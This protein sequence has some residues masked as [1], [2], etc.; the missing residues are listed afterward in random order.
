MKK[1]EH[2]LLPEQSN[3]L[4]EEEAI[5]SISLTRNVAKKINEIIDSI[6]ELDS[7]NYEKHQEQD[8]EIRKGILYMKDNLLNTLH[9]LLELYEKDGFIEKYVKKYTVDLEMQIMNLLSGVSEDGELIDVRYGANGKLYQTAGE[10]IRKQLA[11]LLELIQRMYA[12]NSSVYDLD[13][14]YSF[15]GTSR[16]GKFDSEPFPIPR[17][18]CSIRVTKYIEETINDVSCKFLAR[19]YI[20]KIVKGAFLEDEELTAKYTPGV[21]SNRI[22][23]LPYLEGYAV[24]VSATFVGGGETKVTSQNQEQFKKYLQYVKVYTGKVSKNNS[25]LGY[26]PVTPRK[27][28]T[29]EKYTLDWGLPGLTWKY[30][31][32]SSPLPLKYVKSITVNPDMWVGAKIYKF[33]PATRTTEFVETLHYNDTHPCFGSECHIDFSGYGNNYFAMLILGKAPLNEDYQGISF[34]TSALT[35]DA[36]LLGF[37]L[38]EIESGIHVEWTADNIVSHGLEGLSLPVQKNIELL[39]SLKHKTVPARYG[40]DVSQTWFHISNQDAFS[41]VF[42]GGGYQCGT[43][44]YHISPVA[45][46][47]A[48][49]NPNSNAYGDCDTTKSGQKYGIVCS[50]FTAML[51]GHPIPRSTFDFR[52]NNVEG[53][54]IQ[55]FNLNTDLSKLK[56]YD[57]M[58]QGVGETGHTVLVS[59]L[60]NVDNS[61]T[62]L[63]VMEAVTP[64]TR[65]NVFFL[66][67]GLDYVKPQPEQWYQD[68]YDYAAFSNPEYD[69]TIYDKAN[70]NVPYTEPQKVMCSRGYGSIYLNGIN[71]VILSIDPEVTSI[72]LYKNGVV[73]NTISL[74]GLDMT[75]KNGYNLLDIT[76]YITP[77]EYLIKNNVDDGEEAFNV[78]EVSGYSVNA[79]IEGESVKISTSQFAKAKYVNVIYKAIDGKYEGSTASMCY[80]PAFENGVMIVPESIVTDDNGTWSVS[81]HDNYLDYVNVIFKTDYDT[82]TFVVDAENDRAI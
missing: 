66:H 31:A 37:D 63:K 35:K 12:S 8:G 40:R 15:E 26:T 2:F 56:L 67:N 69:A 30:Q 9:D 52:Y 53:F 34:N 44:F 55:K 29:E 16:Y 10:S 72:T 25:L 65:E 64:A 74:D 62:C 33:N 51:H 81:A 36:V 59:D 82:N 6:N 57:L 48:L 78:I 58:T 27:S 46:Y 19:V 70:W 7:W 60:L 21:Y 32:L 18:G 71:H 77:G 47:T 20:G 61:I 5:S 38:S 23:F 73:A 13:L 76:E 50:N 14:N 22:F 79:T 75:L 45:Y 42:Y 28:D 1:I 3:R 43:F 39:K 4:Y 68:A 24:K 11:E 49:L 54:D 80:P 41:G 17:D